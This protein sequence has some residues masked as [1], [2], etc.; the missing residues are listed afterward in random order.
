MRQIFIADM[1]EV[2]MHHSLCNSPLTLCHTQ[3]LLVSGLYPMEGSLDYEVNLYSIY[4]G[5][6]HATLIMQLTSHFMP[7]TIYTC[8]R[9]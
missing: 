4:V 5:S 6:P 9:F 3:C 1:L 7:H 8:L 2:L